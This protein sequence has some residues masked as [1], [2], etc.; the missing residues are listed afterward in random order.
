MFFMYPAAVSENC[1][2][3]IVA[4]ACKCM[5]RFFLTQIEDALSSGTLRLKQV[6]NSTKDV[7]DPI[8]LEAKKLG[9]TKVIKENDSFKN[10]LCNIDAYRYSKN[11]TLQEAK[12]NIAV[13]SSLRSKIISAG[14]QDKY[15][16]ELD[17]IN[18]ARS[19]YFI[20]SDDKTVK[21]SNAPYKPLDSKIDII[22]TSGVVKV[23]VS[24]IDQ[25][26]D[27]NE[28][29]KEIVVGVKVVPFTMKNFKDV[30][31]ALLDD[32]FS[33]A[34]ESAFKMIER[35]LGS[36]LNSIFHR[37]ASKLLGVV[38]DAQVSSDEYNDSPEKNAL[39]GPKGFVNASA[40]KSNR[41]SPAN[42]KF[43][44]NIVM[45][46]KD[47]LSDTDD[48]NIF[49]NRSAMARL[50]KMGWSTFAVLDPINEE[51]TFI[52]SMDGGYMHVIPYSY[53]METIG[54]RSIYDSIDKI[55]RAAT[56]FLVKK[57]N[58]RTFSNQF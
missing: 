27:I 28:V 15:S 8:V 36:K 46:N 11:L 35:K 56:P 23:E 17:A 19:Q 9:N 47:D 6:F 42:Y 30:E 52:S 10:C 4:P 38:Y 40:F 53:M 24:R 48:Y 37:V 55:R 2:R 13:L 31:T 58:F 21:K 14:L 32:Y 54:T 49:E 29:K 50:F 44:S 43:A 45:F 33:K 34:S 25:N 5:E 18:E 22:P 57:G 41:N 1:D 12:D 26:G 51:M 16:A 7:Y 3:K 20:E 39:Y